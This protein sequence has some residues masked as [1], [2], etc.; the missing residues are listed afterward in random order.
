MI[1]IQLKNNKILW[2][3]KKKLCPKSSVCVRERR[4]KIIKNPQKFYF[5]QKIYFFIHNEF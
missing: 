3:V 1:Y 2:L 4:I 5:Q